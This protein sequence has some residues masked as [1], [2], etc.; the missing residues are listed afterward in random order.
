MTSFLLDGVLSFVFGVWAALVGFGA[1]SLYK[2]REKSEEF[3]R[4]WGGFFKI[5]GSIIAVWGLYNII[6]FLYEKAA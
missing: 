6:R 3:A 2:D 1:T 4:R 5:S